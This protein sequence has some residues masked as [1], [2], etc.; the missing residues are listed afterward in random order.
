MESLNICFFHSR[1]FEDSFENTCEV[2][3]N[4]CNQCYVG[5]TVASVL[6]VHVKIHSGEKPKEQFN[7]LAIQHHLN[8]NY[9]GELTTKLQRLT[10][11][12]SIIFCFVFMWRMSNC[13]L[14]GWLLYNEKTLISGSCCPLQSRLLRFVFFLQMSSLWGKQSLLKTYPKAQERTNWNDD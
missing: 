5:Y 13:P 12:N 4:K 1:Q 3:S 9:A 10:S 11:T 8:Y 7:F 14:E 2:M 6:R